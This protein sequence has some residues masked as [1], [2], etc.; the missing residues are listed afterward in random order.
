MAA[1]PRGQR[2]RLDRLR[3]WTRA[4]AFEILLGAVAVLPI[5]VAAVRAI[6]QGYVAINDDAESA[7]LQKFSGELQDIENHLPIPPAL[8][9][10]KLGA[11][12][13]IVVVNQIFSAGDGNRGVQTAAFNLPNDERVT[14]DVVTGASSLER[15]PD[16][17]VVVVELGLIAWIRK[18]Y[19]D[20]PLVTAV[21]QVV[22]GGFLVFLTGILIGSA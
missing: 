20:T 13:P 16:A 1:L 4:H 21:L 10:P 8:R 22:L 15:L 12:A 6:A 3:A 14:R 2:G 19:M 9:N 7:K 17:L 11:L 5:V 18:Y